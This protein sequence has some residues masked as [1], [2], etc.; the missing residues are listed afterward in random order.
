MELRSQSFIYEIE[1]FISKSPVSTVCLAY[2]R[3]KNF[4][5]RQKVL[6]KMF[7]AKS[8]IYPL[9]LE[10][11]I[12]IRSDYCIQVLNFE[13]VSGGPALIL[14]WVDGFSLEE[15]S[16]SSSLSEGEISFICHQI[17]QG[18]I[19]LKKG[20]ISHGDLSPA[21]VLIDKKGRVQL[22]DFGKGNY[23]D[24]AVFSTGPFTAP[25][26]LKGGRPSFESDL[27][28]LGV[29]EQMLRKSPLQKSPLQTSPLLEKDPK[30]RSLKKF[31]F[32]KDDQKTLA[33]K[34]AKG[35]PLRGGFSRTKPLFQNTKKKLSLLYLS[36]ILFTLLA[37]GL[38]QKEES[39]SIS[40]RGEKWIYI[41]IEKQS[42]ALTQ[43]EAPRTGFTPFFSGPLIPGPYTLSWK[44]HQK[45]GRLLVMIKEGEH[46]LLT[47]GHLTKN[48]N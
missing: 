41:S 1:K 6:L 43:S 18:L 24:G 25:E 5:F 33:S 32:Q 30:K 29:L 16:Y 26:L 8:G 27:F 45:K 11:L 7:K 22:I 17:A 46:L 44:D 38:R 47:H 15:L 10:S 3:H 42:P 14:E 21:N 23:Q 35:R 39:G 36:L 28:S 12:K 13:M 34:A 40:V 19:D 20:G 48:L 9:E 4:P 31:I 2:R 37:G